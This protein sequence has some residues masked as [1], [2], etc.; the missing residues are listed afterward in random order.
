MLDWLAHRARI[1]A[2]SLA[3]IYADECW[4]YAALNDFVARTAGR[5]V[6]AGVRRGQRVA[7]LMPNRSEYAALIHALARLGAILV[8][9]NT[10]L[11]ESELGWQADDADCAWVICS[12]ETEGKGAT[13]VGGNRQIFSVDLP[14]SP[15]VKALADFA[16]VDVGLPEFDLDTVQGIIYTSGTTGRPKGARLTFGNHLWGAMAS[17]YRLG[18]LPADRWLACMPLYH[19]GGQAII[20]R[21]CLYGTTVIL[22]S[23]FETEAVSRALDNQQVTLLSVVPT[24]LHRLLEFRN[25]QPFPSTLRYVL[26]GGAGA[27]APLLDRCRAL[28]VPVALT[29]GLTEAASQVAT[30]TPD[31]VRRKPGSVGKPLMF[32]EARIVDGEGRELPFGQIG[33]IVV[34]GPTVMQGYHQAA[35]ALFAG[36]LHTGDL[37]YVDEEGDLW[38]IQRRTDLIVTGGENVYPAEV[39]AVL[40]AHP[41]VREACVIGIPDPEWGQSVAAVVVSKASDLTERNLIGFCRERL[42]GYKLPRVMLFVDL[43]PQTALGKVDREAAKVL[44][45]ESVRHGNFCFTGIPD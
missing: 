7:V 39:E 44:L 6:T 43:L 33:E 12:R 11:T 22:Q 23:G 10:R 37:G 20:L 29:Y 5:L 42:A 9:L 35:Q 40:L 27:S 17:A 8:P 1:S 14:H 28:G 36:K 13:L 26:L 4:T 34:S 31:Q 19:V 18:T 24:M 25:E 30:A 38:V 16:A 21:C 2:N 32:V 45:K 3:L 41:G 15:V